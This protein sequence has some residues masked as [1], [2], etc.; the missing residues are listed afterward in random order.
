VSKDEAKPSETLEL[1]VYSKPNSFVGLLGV[2]QSVL[3][4]KS[5]NDI[6]KST[7]FHELGKY[8]DIDK[9]NSEWFRDYSY[10]TR[11]DFQSSQ[12]VII[13]NAKKQ[14]GKTE[15]AYY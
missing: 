1:N 12:A 9:H 2:D 4:L 14:F 10:K 5:G 15:N 8:N 6:E 3:L 11:E 13:T 7:V